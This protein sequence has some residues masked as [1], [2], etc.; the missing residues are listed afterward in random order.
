MTTGTPNPPPL[1]DPDDRA[2][3]WF[4]GEPAF[5]A[6]WRHGEALG[7]GPADALRFVLRQRLFERYA[8]AIPTTQ[9]LRALLALGPI[10]EIGAG[11]GYWARLLRDLGGDVIATEP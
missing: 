5:M 7:S 9:A 10:L 8:H 11:A 1:P 2:S 3:A 4:R 6:W